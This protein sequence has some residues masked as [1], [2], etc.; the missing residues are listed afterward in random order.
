VHS[1]LCITPEKALPKSI[2]EVTNIIDSLDK[3]GDG[4]QVSSGK[5]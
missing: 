4:R 2:G 3:E 1:V 5:Y